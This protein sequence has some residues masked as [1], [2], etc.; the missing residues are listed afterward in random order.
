MYVT[1]DG[2]WA[3]L[4]QKISKMRL[5]RFFY[6]STLYVPLAERSTRPVTLREPTQVLRQPW[7]PMS[8]HAF[9]I[10]FSRLSDIP[11]HKVFARRS[12]P[13]ACNSSSFLS[14]H[15][16]SVST[17]ALLRAKVG[18]ALAICLCLHPSSSPYSFQCEEIRDPGSDWSS[19]WYCG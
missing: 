18:V 14:I 5:A 9:A 7:S 17:R 13:A 6:R 2:D 8:N 15:Q 3:F 4:H 11:Y 10:M 12:P 16:V 1:A 19:A